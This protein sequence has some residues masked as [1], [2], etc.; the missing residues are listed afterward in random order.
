MTKPTVLIVDDN[1]ALRETI[2]ENLELDGYAISCVANGNDLLGY[3][4]TKKAD[5]ILLDLI[6]PDGNGLDLIK[7]IRQY[8]DAPVII[9]SGKNESVDKVVGLEM[10][11]DDYITKPFGMHELAARIKANL[12]RYHAYKTPA[13]AA[14]NT[15][16][17][18]KT[19]FENWTLDP[20]TF[21][22]FDGQGQSGNLTVQEFRLLEALVQAAGRVLSREQLMERSRAA[23]HDAY[24]RAIDIQITRIR[25]KIGDDA[26][27]PKIIKTVRGVGYMLA[28]KTD[29]V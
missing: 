8:T 18:Q 21:Q 20:A 24:D 22:I 26:K 9:V 16:T 5:A 25:K 6:L 28:S 11:A 12:R 2:R 3:L 19:K 14:A 1:E 13:P 10:G 15:P 23:G 4:K 27:S 29:P 17:E 7:S